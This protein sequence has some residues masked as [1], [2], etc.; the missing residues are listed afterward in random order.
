MYE[1]FMIFFLLISIWLIIC[2]MLQ[3]DKDVEAGISL[4]TGTSGILFGANHSSSYITRITVILAILFFIISLILGNM[5][6]NQ[7]KINNKWEN[8][9]HIETSNKTINPLSS[10]ISNSDIP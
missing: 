5:S 6:S 10:S 2:I 3:Q 1:I 8:L 9:D 4:G 7:N